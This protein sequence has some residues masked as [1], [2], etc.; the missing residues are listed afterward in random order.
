MIYQIPGVLTPEEAVQIREKLEKARWIE[1]KKTAGISA[2][3]VKTNQ[4]VDQTD[5]VFQEMAQRI[6][7]ALSKNRAFTAKSLPL[8][9]STPHFN[10]YEKGQSYGLHYDNALGSLSGRSGLMRADLSA[11]LFLSD[12][13]DY[14]G[15]EFE[16]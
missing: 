6:L 8:T 12:P 3:P 11:T 2:A 10:R 7:A 16:H 13:A 4:E 15:G 1:G 9:S 5:P 14:D